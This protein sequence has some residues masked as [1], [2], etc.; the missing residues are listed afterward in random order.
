[1]N[2]FENRIDSNRTS[3]KRETRQTQKKTDTQFETK[4]KPNKTKQ[5][6]NVLKCASH[7][8]H[9]NEA[10]AFDAKPA[11]SYFRSANTRMN[12]RTTDPNEE[13]GGGGE[14]LVHSAY[15]QQ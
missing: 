7:H 5:M 6:E 2:S 9:N 4:E 10:N 8:I 12:F 15:T 14:V 1:M 13:G 3:K 11:I